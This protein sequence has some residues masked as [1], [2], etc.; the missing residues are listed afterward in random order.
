MLSLRRAHEWRSGLEILRAKWNVAWSPNRFRA[1]SDTA[2]LGIPP[3][4]TLYR[5]D[6]PRAPGHPL[7][8]GPGFSY[9]ARG[10]CLRSRP[11]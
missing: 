3:N 5:F 10:V 8:E 7:A 2:G 11:V 6:I 9:R 4:P 1:R